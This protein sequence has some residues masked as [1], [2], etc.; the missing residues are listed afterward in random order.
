MNV[1]RDVFVVMA[2]LDDVPPPETQ[3]RRRGFVSY[4]L[5]QLRWELGQLRGTRCKPVARLRGH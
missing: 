3:D 5:R 1:H 4:L 2:G